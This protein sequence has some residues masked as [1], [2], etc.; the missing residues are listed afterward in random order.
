MER[1]RTDIM[2]MPVRI[3][4]PRLDSEELFQQSFTLLEKVDARFSTYKEDSEISRINR[5]EVKRVDA[6]SDIQEVFAIAE[7]TKK[8]TNGYFDIE[9]KDGTLD[10][11]GVVKG[12]AIL[13]VQRLLE[14]AGMRDFMIDI[15]G[16]I[17]SGGVNGKG[18]PWAFGIKNPLASDEIVKVVYPCGRGVATS[19]SYERGA[20]IYNPHTHAPLETIRSVTVIAKDILEADLLAT[21]AF[22]MGEQGIVFLESLPDAEGYAISKDGTA[23]ATSGFSS[24]T[25]PC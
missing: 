7:D 3:V 10:P 9:K 21:S 25:T 13:G 6:G 23:V 16:D 14:G 8:R 12:W 19:G 5:G 15:A 2:G 11:S 20:H 17:A 22:A 24:F 1:L 4:L 18:D